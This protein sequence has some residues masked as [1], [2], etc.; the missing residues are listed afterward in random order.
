MLTCF[1]RLRLCLIV[2]GADKTEEYYMENCGNK[3][4]HL[5][6][7]CT[8]IKSADVTVNVPQAVR[9]VRLALER[10]GHTIDPWLQFVENG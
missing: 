9:M 10:M 1:V 6:N 8:A 7:P 2:T 3:T 5:L 4:P